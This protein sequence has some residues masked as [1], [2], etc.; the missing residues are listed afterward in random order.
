MTTR[1]L[2]SM[3]IIS[4]FAYMGHL[5]FGFNLRAFHSLTISVSTLLRFPLG[6]FD[7]DAMR[8]CQPERARESVCLCVSP[9]LHL[10]PPLSTSL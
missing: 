9:P 8:V 7:Y 4:G 2:R 1:S 6:D 3:V 10:A 5:Y